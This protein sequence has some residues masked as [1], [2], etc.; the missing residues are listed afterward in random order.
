MNQQLSWVVFILSIIHLREVQIVTL[1]LFLVSS[2]PI[3]NHQLVPCFYIVPKTIES[4][5]DV[6]VKQTR[7]GM[8]D[9][10]R[11]LLY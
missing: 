11:G 10:T 6:D 2:Y 4:N 3:L 5:L 9:P 8:T 7:G 1:I